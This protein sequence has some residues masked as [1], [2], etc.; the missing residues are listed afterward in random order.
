[1]TRRE[2]E[3]LRNGL[4]FISPW[5]IGISG[6]IIYPI[7]A[8]FYYSLCEYSVLMPAQFI[9]VGNYTDLMTD[10]VFWKALWNTFYY[11]FFALPLG[12]MVAITLAL[13]LNL[14]IRG[15][16][17][18]RTIFFLP[19]LVPMIALAILWMWIFNGQ[20][21]ILNYILSFFGIHGPNWLVDP[22]WTKPALIITGI[23]GVGQAVVIYLAGLQN[24]PTE[25]YEAAELDGAKSFRKI[26]HVTLPMISPVIY[27]NFIMGLI[28]TLQIFAVPYVLNAPARSL[29]FYTMYLYDNAF[30]YLRMGYASAMAWILFILIV[31]LAAGATQLSKKY[32]YYAGK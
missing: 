13:L 25:L 5:I 11:A 12:T 2:K 28:G 1:M 19:S 9:G 6:F 7:C 10:E 20:Y 27:F 14:D 26:W 17:F 8:S 15:R 24:V 30:R 23:W 22:S 31:L 29:L 4:L 18:F 21:G 16:A 3:N 32:I